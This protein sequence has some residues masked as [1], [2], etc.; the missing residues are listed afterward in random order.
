M[1]PPATKSCRAAAPERAQYEAIEN[2][3]MKK[4]TK[5]PKLFVQKPYI[6]NLQVQFFGICHKCQQLKRLLNSHTNG[7]AEYTLESQVPCNY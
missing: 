2:I 1:S 3:A 6:M 7:F 5:G 4:W